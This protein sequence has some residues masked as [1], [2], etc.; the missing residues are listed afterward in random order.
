MCVSTEAGEHVVVDCIVVRG[1][2]TFWSH[3]YA[4]GKDKEI[5][6]PLQYNTAVNYC[7]FPTL[8]HIFVT[9]K[10]YFTKQ[11]S[12]VHGSQVR[13]TFFYVLS[14]C[15]YLSR[16]RYE[17]VLAVCSKADPFLPFSGKGLPRTAEGK[18]HCP[19]I[20][21][22]L[23]CCFFAGFS[24]FMSSKQHINHCAALVG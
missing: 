6:A 4:N 17:C 8:S 15:P 18:C 23:L 19:S 16:L 20:V 13:Y 12:T 2:P 7:T 24:L 22:C 5:G 11:A 9:I 10:A 3:L 21:Y 14:L 1:V